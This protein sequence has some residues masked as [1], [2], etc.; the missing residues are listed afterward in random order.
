MAKAGKQTTGQMSIP[1][2]VFSIV[3]AAA[4]ESTRYAI[5]G[6]GLSV[7]NGRC[8]AAC[9]DGRMMARLDWPPDADDPPPAT[10]K[11]IASGDAWRATRRLLGLGPEAGRPQ[12]AT[13]TIGDASAFT[14]KSE[15]ATHT[16]DTATCDLAKFPDV[17]EVIPKYDETNSVTIAVDPLLLSTLL[18]IM[19]AAATSDESKAV[20]LTVPND[21]TS[22]LLLTSRDV[23]HGVNAT[24]VLMPR[25]G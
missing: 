13:L 22:P 12:E 4:E 24:C 18:D 9:T 8:Q 16:V 1:A 11:A 5:N 17:K 20:V 3:D 7:E 23:E 10:F 14:A 6:V 2:Q 25:I 19:R 21:R 15:H